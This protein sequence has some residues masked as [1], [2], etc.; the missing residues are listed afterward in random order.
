[1]KS[2]S[3]PAA[4][5]PVPPAL[6]I[7]F[8]ILAVS[9]ASIFI[10]YAQAEGAPSLV[11]AAFR[12]TL[13]SLILAPLAL[14][15]YR[16]ELRL[17][18]RKEI[19]LALL[20]GLFLA[21]HFAAWITS[22]EYTSV[23]SSV[24]LV[25]TTPLWVAILAPL[26][27]KE[28]VTRPVIM[29]M[30][31]ALIGGTIVG[32]SDSCAWD[33]AGLQCPPLSEFVGGQAFLGD[34]LALLGAFTAAGYMLVGR[35]LRDKMSLIPYIFAVYGMAAVVLVLVMFG[36]GK[37]PTGYAP[38]T[39][40]WF[41]LLAL[42]PQLLGHSTF[43]W[44][45]RYLPAAYVSLTLLGEPIGS[46]ILAYFFLDEIPAG[47]MVFGAILILAGIY[48]ASRRE[49]KHF[50]IGV[51]TVIFDPQGR[52]LLCH[53]RDLDLWNLPGG[54]MQPGELPT[55]AAIRE[56]REETGLRVEIER[57]TGVYSKPR[58]N[59]LVFTFTAR[60]TAGSLTLNAE[61]DQLEYF[62]TRWPA[63]QHHS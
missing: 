19:G 48:V 12:L 54:G 9:T 39:Y 21:I 59:D 50:T 40:L 29:G 16:S 60:I 43:N 51:F 22:L 3:E 25:S 33:L 44:A 10:R 20:S 30:G 28:P 5:P 31:L 63:R 26:T 55:E 49:K 53:R 4:K 36:A 7:P 8:G 13:A 1:M 11:I 34:L 62:P 24:V 23:A 32:L 46:A 52:V 35:R 2:L 14:W 57:L 17:R 38:Q 56:T 15:R 41:V 27:I 6:A 58:N 61:A 18:T 47:L 37:S 45:L 42:V